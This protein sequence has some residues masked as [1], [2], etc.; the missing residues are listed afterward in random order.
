MRVG[1]AWFGVIALDAIRRM[2]VGVIAAGTLALVGCPDPEVVLRVDSIR[3]TIPRDDCRPIPLPRAVEAEALGDFAP[4]LEHIA[5]L[6]PED[7]VTSLDRFPAATRLIAFRAEAGAWRAAGVHAPLASGGAAEALLLPVGRSCSFASDFELRAPPDSAIAA[8]EDG[9]LLIVGG[10]RSESDEGLRRVV[11]FPPGGGL[12]EVLADDLPIR[13]IGASA[14]RVGPLVVIAGGSPFD[15]DRALDTFDVFDAREGRFV[16]TSGGLCPD[17]AIDCDGTRRDHG[18]GAMIDGRVLLFGGVATRGG[19]PLA[20]TVIIDPRT[21]AVD[22]EVDPVLPVEPGMPE[23][24]ILARRL[25][26]IVTL[27]NGGTYVVG[28]QGS[29]G[30]FTG[31][32]YWFDPTRRGY[33]KV[34]IGAS[35][36]ERVLPFVQGVAVAL[37]GARMLW[38]EPEG[39]AVVLLFDESETQ[40][41]RLDFGAGWPDTAGPIEGLRAVARSDGQ[42]HV[43]GEDTAGDVRAFLVDPGRGSITSLTGPALGSAPTTLV[44][45]DTGVV[46]EIEAEGA[47]LRRP[48]LRTRFDHPPATLLP[49]DREWIAFDAAAGWTV[50]DEGAAADRVAWMILPTL[51]FASFKL[52]L[53]ADPGV[54]IVLLSESGHRVRIGLAADVVS[55]GLCALDWDGEVDVEVTREQGVLTLG[56]AAGAKS[57]RVTGL[58]EHVQLMF[59]VEPSAAV[60][61][62]QIERRPS[63]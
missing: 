8:L 22:V 46:A 55:T 13:R 42:V 29:G 50:T 18:A 7:G 3:L 28:G 15:A 31:T 44:A 37:P 45:L 32:V 54:E 9:G 2:A 33:E 23:E 30:G 25:P 11:R 27:D 4:A 47:A 53:D 58:S 17:G 52:T 10:R 24:R 51:S 39:A 16:R 5:V 41:R 1:R 48:L 36:S 38:V 57:C 12:S 6:G 49:T 34:R 14:T 63:G 40:V 21:G 20:T 60:R 59:R 61:R 62:L 56:A 43:T 26:Q 19:E 35:G